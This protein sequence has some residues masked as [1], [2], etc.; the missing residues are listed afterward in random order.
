M[1]ISAITGDQNF[2]NGSAKLHLFFVP[3]RQRM[4]QE[5]HIGQLARGVN[6]DVPCSATNIRRF[7]AMNGAPETLGKWTQANYDV[8]EGVVL[9]LFGTRRTS[10][11]GQNIGSA[12]A[13]IYVQARSNAALTSIDFSLI[14]NDRSPITRAELQGRFDILTGAELAQLGV[15]MNQQTLMSMSERNVSRVFALRT[16]ERQLQAKQT[17]R[18][19][20]VNNSDGEAVVIQKQ[21]ARRAVKL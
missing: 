5:V 10:I 1:L 16:L 8:P 12:S 4:G 15:S 9:K 13:V 18:T 3:T 14:P 17:V 19:T 20:T 2:P 7:N 11:Q 6:P 21:V